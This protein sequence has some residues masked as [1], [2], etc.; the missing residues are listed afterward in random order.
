MIEI[1]FCFDNNMAAAAC[2]AI[3]SLLDF[4]GD[5]RV[6]YRISC[7]CPRETF[8]YKLKIESI[9]KKR[10]GK[11]T[12]DFYL[13]PEEF[14]GA[15]EVR[16]ISV[17]TYLR[18]LLHRI[19]PEK[20]KI[21]YADVDILFQDTL[22]ALWDDNISGFL[23]GGV[24]GA[25]N[26]R[27]TWQ[28]SMKLPYAEK[29]KDVTGNYINAGILI[30]NLEE[31]RRWN[32]DESWLQMAGENYY[33]Q[34]QDILNI[35]CKGKVR[36]LPVR[37][38]VQAHLTTKEFMRF[39]KEGIFSKEQCTEAVKRPAVLHYTGPK[40][41]DNR[42]VNRGKIWWGYV[43]SQKDLSCFFDETK[44]MNRKT[45]G[46]LGKINRHLPFLK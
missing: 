1:A 6:H 10:D 12:V 26:F 4:N 9:V 21:I 2:V 30:M 22:K 32:P 5:K 44:V 46:L 43:E 45:T 11:S 28:E 37:Y 8:D 18:L 14:D 29:L 36:Y 24:K 31:I 34:D 25:A 7:I 19:F 15:Y 42:G 33:Y 27:N 20:R 16:G 39:A 3:A 23:I 41:W 13:A 38:N 17:S 40:P 35:T